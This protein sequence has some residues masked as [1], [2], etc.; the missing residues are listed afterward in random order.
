MENEDGTTYPPEFGCFN[1]AS[2][3]YLFHKCQIANLSIQTC[4]AEKLLKTHANFRDRER[5]VGEKHI[6]S[7]FF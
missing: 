2:K 5:K 1:E 3:L 4:I 6:F 7:I